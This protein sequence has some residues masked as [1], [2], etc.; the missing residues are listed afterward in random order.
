MTINEIKKQWV[1]V[2]TVG[3]LTA[4]GIIFSSCE[5]L[6]KINQQLTNVVAKQPLARSAG[7]QYATTN[8]YLS[9]LEIQ[10]P[11]ER[12][13]AAVAQLPEN[14]AIIFVAPSR[15]PEIELTYRVIAS[16]S[17]PHEVGALHCSMGDANVNQSEL[18]FQ[19][20]KEKQV[21]WLFFYRIS[22]PAGLQPV[23]EI[24]SH[25]KLISIKE[26]KEW[27]SYCSPSPF[28]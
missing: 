12:V 24:G 15:T 9:S 18:L 2:S 17:W 1:K 10:N 5:S 28:C 27:I 4:G 19:P 6:S 11:S 20:R 22:P 23:T 21:R 8:T 14:D 13:L 3:L 26:T 25:L 7:G 16:L